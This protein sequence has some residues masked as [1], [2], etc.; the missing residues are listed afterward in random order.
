MR[1][2][3]TA[4]DAPASVIAKSAATAKMVR[5]PKL[6]RML[7]LGDISPK[8]DLASLQLVRNYRPDQRGDS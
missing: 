1:V 6:R 4:N 7:L 5:A 3:M 2:G 8:R